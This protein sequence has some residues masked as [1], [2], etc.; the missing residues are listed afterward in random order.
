MWVCLLTSVH[1]KIDQ[2]LPLIIASWDYAGMLPIM[3]HPFLSS[4]LVLFYQ[5]VDI[6]LEQQMLNLDSDVVSISLV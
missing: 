6:F 5:Q 3:S 2:L 1:P 4:H